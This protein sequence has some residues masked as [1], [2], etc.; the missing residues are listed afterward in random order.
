M[1]R[2]G[3]HLEVPRVRNKD[4]ISFHFSTNSM[5]M[6]DTENTHSHQFSTISILHFESK[7]PPQGQIKCRNWGPRSRKCR[8]LGSAS[9]W[10]TCKIMQR[11]VIV[12]AI[13]NMYTKAS[14]VKN[15]RVVP[16]V[17]MACSTNVLNEVGKTPQRGW[18]QKVLTW[19]EVT[20]PDQWNCD[21]S[22]E[23][24]LKDSDGLPTGVPVRKPSESFNSTSTDSC[25][26]RTS[27]RRQRRSDETCN[28]TLVFHRP[29]QRGIPKG[30]ATAEITTA[31]KAVR[32]GW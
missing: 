17:P 12:A 10:L 5:H 7:G 18:T 32:E 22:V 29:P 3:P 26:L 24:E 20:R 9:A 28:P 19:Q 16:F 14:R 1:E 8:K 27:P 15:R 23:V 4:Q 2:H 11:H 6:F 25:S 13:R 30:S 31:P 21:V